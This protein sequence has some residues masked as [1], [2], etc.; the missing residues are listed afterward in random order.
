MSLTKLSCN[1]QMLFFQCMVL[2]ILPCIVFAQLSEEALKEHLPSLD[3]ET[4]E[5]IEQA[6]EAGRSPADV[7]GSYVSEF[8]EEQIADILGKL[9]EDEIRDVI[10]S[11][12]IDTW[13]SIIT[14]GN[15]PSEILG[16]LPVE[17]PQFPQIPPLG[18][19]TSEETSTEICTVNA[20]IQPDLTGSLGVVGAAEGKINAVGDSIN[21]AGSVLNS[22]APITN[23]LQAAGILGS[24]G[25]NPINIPSLSSIID[26]GFPSV[27]GFG[28]FGG[29]GLFGV[30][31]VAH[32]VSDPLDCKTNTGD[33]LV[34]EQQLQMVEEV[35]IPE[36]E[37]VY[38]KLKDEIDIASV[39]EQELE[40]VIDSNSPK[41]LPRS[42][43][44][45][46]QE[47][48]NDIIEDEV[49]ALLKCQALGPASQFDKD[50]MDFNFGEVRCEPKM[51][52][53]GTCISLG[54]HNI[55][56]GY[57]QPMEIA[58]AN[59]ANGPKLPKELVKTMEEVVLQSETF[60]DNLLRKASIWM[61]IMSIKNQGKDPEDIVFDQEAFHEFM[62]WTTI[63]DILE[64]IDEYK[65]QHDLFVLP[66]D[67]MRSTTMIPTL[68]SI[69]PGGSWLADVE[70]GMIW[71]PLIR[72]HGE[73]PPPNS[74]LYQS[75]RWNMEQ[76]FIT[77]SNDYALRMGAEQAKKF[78]LE[79]LAEV[80]DSRWGL[81]AQLSLQDQMCEDESA[82]SPDRWRCF[83]KNSTGF[84]S[85]QFKGQRDG[86]NH[87]TEGTDGST[88]LC[89]AE[90]QYI[91]TD[92]WRHGMLLAMKSEIRCRKYM[93]A[94]SQENPEE[95]LRCRYDYRSYCPRDAFGECEC[96]FNEFKEAIGDR[97]DKCTTDSILDLDSGESFHE[98]HRVEAYKFNDEVD[99]TRI[100]SLRDYDKPYVITHRTM[101]CPDWA[102][103]RQATLQLAKMGVADIEAI[104][105]SVWAALACGVQRCDD[106]WKYEPATASCESTGVW[107]PQSPLE[108]GIQRVGDCPCFD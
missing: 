17:L 65:K 61:N 38:S 81:A 53:L 18:G 25:L 83:T 16:R 60:G 72:A 66:A 100:E 20:G 37:R 93:S 58:Y 98:L 45:E 82:D 101:D 103:A 108:S 85:S 71:T 106:D 11:I 9:P 107:D 62:S 33:T 28:G 12:P 40:G 94:L 90:N 78:G 46:M 51:R 69:L 68:S 55:G 30:P 73:E 104:W 87:T 91:A 29:G 76:Y 35:H 67:M 88:T 50:C 99:E 105:L 43:G 8:K 14:S 77:R 2:F 31:L 59:S 97:Q 63:D 102:E 92:S 27:G 39:L 95:D 6:L 49:T 4:R 74:S 52:I 86:V 56:V 23:I 13:Q 21:A 44:Q 34:N 24:I 32:P 54:C 41:P 26:I 3:P 47:W 89:G 5:K 10:N 19:T 84:Q 36:F 1:V 70:K 42:G 79:R 22:I 57:N 7:F 15:L 75:G 48:L 96:E 64:E 80:L